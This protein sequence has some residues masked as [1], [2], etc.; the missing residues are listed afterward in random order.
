MN[1]QHEQT[2]YDKA[3]HHTDQIG[4]LLSHILNTIAVSNEKSLASFVLLLSAVPEYFGMY[5]ATG[6]RAIAFV[7]A[8][9]SVVVVKLALRETPLPA[10]VRFALPRNAVPVFWL[11]YAAQIA[12]GVAFIWESGQ[13]VDIGLI[14][15]SAV[16]AVCSEKFAQAVRDGLAEAATVDYEAEKQRI[17]LEEMQA[18]SAARTAAYE[19]KHGVVV[20]DDSKTTP[21]SDGEITV[22]SAEKTAEG[23]KNAQA[24][25]K[26]KAEKRRD[27][28]LE[29]LI[30]RYP[31]VALEEIT[32]KSMGALVG[33]TGDTAKRDIE[34][35][36]SA[37][38]IN[39]VVPNVPTKSN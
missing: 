38:R 14:V 17:R 11:L 26:S 31:G 9:I 28:L 22:I 16:G 33:V 13:Y 37:A 8:A 23:L 5:Q 4:D 18:K 25:R 10:I 29:L 12:A 27:T 24:A 1:N 2:L 32:Y 30:E 6:N 20:A 3:R 39:G 15:M 34:A 19:A 7:A 36:R 35:L 21:N